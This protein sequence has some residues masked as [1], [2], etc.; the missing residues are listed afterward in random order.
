MVKTT[1]EYCMKCK[2]HFGGD[3]KQSSSRVCCDYI[4]KT[5][6]RR[7]CPV[8]KCDKFV[9]SDGKEKNKIPW[10]REILEMSELM[11]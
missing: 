9:K 8:G 5:G 1:T 3:H 7:G 4:L 2:Y 11:S 10:E 6:K